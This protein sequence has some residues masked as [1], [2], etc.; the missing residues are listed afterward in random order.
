MEGVFG[1]G[2][3][4]RGQAKAARAHTGLHGARGANR[5]AVIKIFNNNNRIEKL[6]VTHTEMDPKI[7][8]ATGWRPCI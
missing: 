2:S 1:G 3:S 6:S 5:E 7:D 8:Q 4:E